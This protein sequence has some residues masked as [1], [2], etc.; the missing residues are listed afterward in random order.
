MIKLLSILNE[1]SLYSKCKR[2]YILTKKNKT[3]SIDYANLEAEFNMPE[4]HVALR[5]CKTADEFARF[6]MK[7]KYSAYNWLNT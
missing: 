5:N 6:I 1:E 4:I 7:D 3:S 2:Y